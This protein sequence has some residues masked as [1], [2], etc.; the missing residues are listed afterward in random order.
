MLYGLLD[1]PLGRGLRFD[2]D[3][4]IPDLNGKVIIVTG[5]NVGLGKETVLRLSKHNPKRI[6]MLARN[7]SKAETAIEDIQSTVPTALISFIQCDLT[8]LKSVETAAREF[9]SKE[10]KLDILFLNAGIMATPAGLT[11][12]GY[13]IQFGTNHVGHALLTKLLLPTLLK[14]AEEPGSDVRVIC[15]SSIGHVGA[16]WSGINF[17]TLKTE[18]AWTP[19]MIRYGQSKL[20]NILF[21][22]ELVK[23]YPKILAVSVHPG[24]VNTELYRSVFSGWMSSLNFATS[25][26][27]T[28]EVGAKNQLWAGT[29]RRED[30]K[31]GEY[32]TPVGVSGQGSWKSQD[33]ALAAKLWEWTEKELEGYTPPTAHP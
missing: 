7:Q 19:T 2:P 9:S 1:Q 32:Y 13:E 29:A 33:M 20:A 21:I 17:E 18:M 15:V 31:S 4:D 10:Q 11:K 8:D 12:D 24:A 30:I 27:D 6:Y 26:M 3:S 25:G 28:I 16:P 22:R 23:R 14:T 5:A